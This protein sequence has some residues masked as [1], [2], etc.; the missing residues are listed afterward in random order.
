MLDKSLIPFIGMHSVTMGVYQVCLWSFFVL[1]TSE[2][3]LPMTVHTPLYTD[4]MFRSLQVQHI[5]IFC[6]NP[7]PAVPERVTILVCVCVSQSVCLCV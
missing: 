6:I 7:W 5:V 1:V 3:G 2:K 4:C